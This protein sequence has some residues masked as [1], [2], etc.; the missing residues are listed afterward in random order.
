MAFSNTFTWMPSD[1]LDEL[2]T[3]TLVYIA[4]KEVIFPKTGI[5]KYSPTN[6]NNEG[7]D[8]MR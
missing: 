5:A 4:M 8:I 1:T 3:I 7:K 2:R 6:S